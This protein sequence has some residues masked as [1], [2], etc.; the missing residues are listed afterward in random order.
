MS[1]EQTLIT[2]AHIAEQYG[3]PEPLVA[4]GLAM[5][6]KMLDGALAAIAAGHDREKMPTTPQAVSLVIF[7]GTM[8]TMA[9]ERL[10]LS[11][12]LLQFMSR[13]EEG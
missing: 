7:W 5:A 10:P 2:V 9:E 13:G 3:L 8:M 4:E 11:K 1:P 12:L 6:E